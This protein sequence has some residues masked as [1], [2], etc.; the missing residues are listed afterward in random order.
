[1]NSLNGIKIK[2]SSIS[3]LFL[4]VVGV[5]IMGMFQASTAIGG[6]APWYHTAW[7]KRQPITI[8]HSQVVDDLT[9]FPVLITEANI[10]PALFENAK[11]DGSD[12]VLTSGDG[13]TMLKRELVGFD[14][15]TNKMELYAK[16]PFLSSTTDTLLYIYYQNPDASVVNDS[17]TWDSHYI[18]V[19]HMEDATSGSILGSTI[20]HFIGDKGDVVNSDPR[21]HVNPSVEVEGKIGMAQDFDRSWINVG[22]HSEFNLRQFFTVEVWAFPVRPDESSIMGLLF[23]TIC[24]TLVGAVGC[25]NIDGRVASS[26]DSSSAEKWWRSESSRRSAKLRCLEPYCCGVQF[27]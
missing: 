4:L 22:V 12:I 6:D 25:S 2:N 1:M 19:Q 8:Y 13:V 9:D 11:N 18:M 15:S 24:W 27:R 26:G 23:P 14:N 16:V 10:N 3:E 5:L 20:N 17:D 7:A 21:Y